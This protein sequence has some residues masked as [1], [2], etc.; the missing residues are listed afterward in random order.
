MKLLLALLVLAACGPS[1]KKLCDTSVLNR[2]E[3]RYDGQSREVLE[4][5]YYDF[6]SG[7]SEVCKGEE[8]YTGPACLERALLAADT[9]ARDGIPDVIKLCDEHARELACEWVR[10]H[11]P[12][13]AAYDAAKAEQAAA[14][15]QK[16]DF[17]DSGMD[18][19]TFAAQML[20]AGVRAGAPVVHD[21]SYYVDGTYASFS[22]SVTPGGAYKFWVIGSS[23]DSFDAKVDAWD[24]EPVVLYPQADVPRTVRSLNSILNVP[25]GVTEVQ[26]VITG[27]PADVRAMVFQD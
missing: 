10:T 15:Q 24:Y 2:A 9:G 16:Q 11:Q 19:A 23:A 20:E 25:D 26:V 21:Q 18:P 1:P 17:I 3:G 14:D 8:G 4:Q 27:G 22:I 6:A 13:I 12:E 7:C 5:S